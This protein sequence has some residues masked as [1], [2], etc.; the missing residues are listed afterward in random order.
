M[1]EP[2]CRSQ[3]RSG[4]DGNVRAVGAVPEPLGHGKVAEILN[5][6]LEIGAGHGIIRLLS[7]KGLVLFFAP[8]RL[9]LSLEQTDEALMLAFQKGETAAFEVLLK[10]HE[11]GVYTF[12]KRHL[13]NR[14]QAEEVTQESFLRVIKASSRY[15]P[16]AGF[17]NYLYQIARNLCLDILRRRSRGMEEPSVD[18]NPAAMVESVPNGNPGPESRVGARQMRSALQRALDQLPPE[19]REVFL[20]KEVKDMKLQDVARVT[21][22]NLNTVKSRL[23][24]A[25]AGLRERLSADGIGREADNGV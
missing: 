9:L 25:L 24:Y 22:T 16:T 1:S 10:R 4:S 13:G 21:G 19:Q 15:R 3:G 2:L 14:M 6:N 23:R 5:G 7:S 18:P 12:A 20:L 11:R 17:R 8:R